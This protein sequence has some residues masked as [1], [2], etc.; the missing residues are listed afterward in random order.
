M[1]T[2]YGL[3]TRQANSN[4]HQT[5]WVT[6]HKGR[7]RKHRKA[8]STDTRVRDRTSPDSGLQLY[9]HCDYGHVDSESDTGARGDMKITGKA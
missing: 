5:K 6:R 4:A 2:V 8:Q 3:I 9:F 1:T 7:R